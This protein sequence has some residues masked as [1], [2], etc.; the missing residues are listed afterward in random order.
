MNSNLHEYDRENLLRLASAVMDGNSSESQ[1]EQLTELL[2]SDA[3]ARDEYLRFVDMHAVLA[4]DQANTRIS[5]NTSETRTV[6]TSLRNANAL[7]KSW[8]VAAGISTLVVSVAIAILPLVLPVTDPGPTTQFATVVQVANAKW[9]SQ[10]IDVGDR[11][12]RETI[13]L[14]EG[15]ARLAFDSGVE[16]TLQAPAE[17]ELASVTNA[18]LRSGLLTATVPSGEEGF[19]LKTPTAEVVDLG[20]SFGIDLHNDGSSSVSV[21]AGEVEVGV[22]DT[23]ERRVLIEG[24]AVRIGVEKEIESV[25]FDADP[26]EKLWPISSGITA[27]SD[28]FRFVPPWPRRIRFVTSDSEIFV[29]AEGQTIELVDPLKVN[30]SASGSC[31]HM[32]ELTPT[33]LAAGTLVRSY[34]FHYSPTSNLAPRK[35]TRVKGVISFDR[36]ILGLIVRHEEL[37]ASMGKFAQRRLGELHPRRQTDFSDERDGDRITLSPDRKTLS[38]DLIS[39]GRSSDLVRVILS[40]SSGPKAP[41]PLRN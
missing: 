22:R 4:T 2:R 39:P 28:V 9:D 40:A 25:D 27:S 1:R 35:A 23:D 14:A 29:A 31:A 11:L 16:V 37:V 26:F 30:I 15:F 19:T 38:L 13:Q 24:E 20:T 10:P 41:N 18:T 17:L 32:D 33:E 3:D 21:F 34:I 12:G 6:D 8:L 7:R 5:A 36:P